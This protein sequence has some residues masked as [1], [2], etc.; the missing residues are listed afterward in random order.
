MLRAIVPDFHAASIDPHARAA[1]LRD[2]VRLDPE[3]LVFLGDGVD[4][5][6]LF[7]KHKPKALVD[8]AYSYEEDIEAANSFLDDVQEAAPR[9]KRVHYLMGN[10]EWHVERW[11]CENLGN[12][13]DAKY[14]VKK[15]GP[16]TELKLD[17]RGFRVYEY[18]ERYQGLAI[19]NT[20]R[21]GKCYF[22]HGIAANKF[23]T[24]KHVEEFG[25]CVVHG[26]TH[27]AQE[28]RKKTITSEAI[29]GWCPGTL[30]KLQPTYAHTTPTAWTHG[31]GLQFVDKKSGSF[32]HINVPIV[33][34]RSL[35]L[36]LV[37]HMGAAA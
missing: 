34:G 12:R 36:P 22:T 14:V 4:A 17:A 25:A 13:K 2:L 11:A 16:R 32:L 29:A 5:S 8:L 3:E 19:P 21:L 23:A 27:R 1:F 15:L 28:Y 20:I 35:L 10:H 24:A 6:G 7:S 30:A 31:Y 33:R 9:C 37:Q 18:L 26:H